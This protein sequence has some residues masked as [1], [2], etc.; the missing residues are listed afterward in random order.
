[1]WQRGVGGSIPSMAAYVFGV[2]GMFR[3]VRGALSPRR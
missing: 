1:M 3:L 2:I